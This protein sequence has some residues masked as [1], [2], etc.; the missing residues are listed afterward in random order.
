MRVH[1]HQNLASPAKSHEE[2]SAEAADGS[3]LGHLKTS[4]LF[5][6]RIQLLL[7]KAMTSSCRSVE[8]SADA[9][10]AQLTE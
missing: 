7:G 1:D 9:E 6:K 3:D 2:S 8:V 4:T 10:G 5:L